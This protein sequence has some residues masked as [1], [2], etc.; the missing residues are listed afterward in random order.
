MRASRSNPAGFVLAIAALSIVAGLSGGCASRTWNEGRTQQPE[1]V[2]YTFANRL[3]RA[4]AQDT[5]VVLAF[6]GGGTR[7]AA[8]SYGVLETLRD[9]PVTI[10]GVETDLL[11]E[12]DVITSV[13]GGSFTAAYYGLFGDRI[14]RDF[15]SRFLKRDVQGELIATLLNPYNALNVL[16]SGYNRADLAA[17]WF[18]QNLF[19]GKTYRDMGR[20]ELP[21]VIIN[22]SDLNTGSTF[23]FIQQQFDF[24]CS[25]LTNYPVGSAVMASSALP[26]VFGPISIRN[27]DTD[28]AQRRS[29]WVHDVLRTPDILSRNYQVAKALE[30][31]FDPKRMP[32]IRLVDGGVTDN[33]GVRGSIM[34]PIAHYGNVMEMK[35]AFTTEAL[36]RVTRVL[37]VVANAQVYPEYGWSQSGTEPGI[38]PEL[39]ASFD[40]ALNIM[41]TETISLA[42]EAFL[43]WAEHTNATRDNGKPPVEVTFVVLTFDGIRD[44][45][46]RRYFNAIPTVSSLSG[47]QVDR[48]RGLARRLLT[49]SPEF[50]TFKKSLK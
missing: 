34:S 21:F 39:L 16:G 40:A 23:S 50:K 17:Q 3:P 43:R 18:D 4:N 32:V 6:S 27:F 47:E 9:T 29:S 24:L 15:E 38:V 33:L 35:G 31:Y 10:G 14:F 12:V 20:G 19:D 48:V 49:E 5:F 36:S 42:K 26:V 22:A 28:C 8:F 11:K 2:Q 7:S 44:V 25:D 45:A 41:N 37:V 1:S 46:E 30:R 13:S